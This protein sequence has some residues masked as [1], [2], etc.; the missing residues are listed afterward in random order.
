MA[1][2]TIE[3]FGIDSANSFTFANVSA[4]GNVTGTYILGNGSALTGITAGLKWTTANTAPSSP[5]PGDFWYAGNTSVKYQYTN[6]GTANYWVDQSFPTSFST[7]AVTGNG[8]VG[9]T[10]IVTGNTTGG[11]I[12][13]AGLMS[14]T[15]NAIHGN[16]LT[17]GLVSATGNL[18]GNFIN[19]NGFYLTGITGSGVP[20]TI[21]NGNSNVAVASANANVTVSVSTVGNI[22]VF[23][24][25]GISV[26]GTIVG[27]GNITGGNILTVGLMSSTGNIT[28]GNI[29]TGGLVSATGN[30]T[31]GNLS[32]GTGTV[33]VGNIVNS[34]GNAVG[35]IGSSSLYFNTVFAK[36]TS[37]LYAD[38]AEM[39]VADQ[40]YAP[41]TV[42]E[43]GDP[44]E[45]RASQLSHSSAVAGIV[46]TN[47]SY[48][49]NAA[50]PGT[51]VLPVALTGRVPCCVVGVIRKGTR[52][53]ASDIPG[54][55]TALDNIKYQPGCIIGKALEAYNS[56]EIGTIEVAVGRD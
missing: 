39:Y 27:N 28:G 14:S 32:V 16:I 30:I 24:T 18:T 51:H 52:L 33:T 35:N 4:T 43:F 29:L 10:F 11:N 53:V 6:D 5:A 8:T 42:V 21:V 38:L 17:G 46:S 34:N 45:I 37:A 47:P 3:P 1:L 15:G 25:T 23:S 44:E 36:A 19:G 2:T 55:A 12:L 7:L 9:G 54:V 22:A 40:D 49:M 41:G 48:L 20:T 31:S 13:T 56:N 26:L 50:Q